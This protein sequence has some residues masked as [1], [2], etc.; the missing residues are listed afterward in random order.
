MKEKITE[1]E[2]L[3]AV[4]MIR[5]SLGAHKEIKDTLTMLRLNRVNHCVLVP[6][7]PVF[8]GMLKKAESY[9]TW[10]EIEPSILDILISK[11]GRLSGNEKIPKEKVKEIVKTI[12]KNK[13]VKGLSIKPVFR[14]SPPSKGY[15]SIKLPFPKGAAGYRGKK[16]NELLRKMI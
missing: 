16:I 1:N 5:S 13:S 10:G 2:S 7:L 3:F 6:K 9:I 4:I 8:Q 15:K 12:L 14:L 11:R